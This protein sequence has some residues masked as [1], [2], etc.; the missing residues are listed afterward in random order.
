MILKTMLC[1][2]LGHSSGCL[3]SLMA[4]APSLTILSKCKDVTYG[5]ETWYLILNEKKL[6]EDISEYKGLRNNEGRAENIK[7]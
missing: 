2:V 7:N 6:I 5:H 3:P 1:S 4:F